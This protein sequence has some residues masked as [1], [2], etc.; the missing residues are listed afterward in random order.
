MKLNRRD[1]VKSSAFA[2]LFAAGGCATDGGI[3]N[4]V[5]V[6]VGT[7]P[8]SGRLNLAIVGCGAMGVS[9]LRQLWKDPRVRFVAAC[10]P[11][12]ES[13]FH[14][15]DA[16]TL[17]GRDPVKRLIDAKYQTSATKSVADWREVI[18]DPDVDAVLVSTG[19]Y[20]HALISAE[21]MKAGKHVYCQKPLTLGVN[22][23]KVLRTIAAKTGRIFQVGSQQRSDGRFRLAAELVRNHALGD[24]KSCTIGLCY[25]HN[26]SLKNG[27]T[28]DCTPQGIP[29]WL[30]DKAM[31]DLYLG[32]VRHWENDAY[33]PAIHAPVCWRWNSRTGNGS[34]ADWGAHHIDIL[35]WA[36]GLDATGG[37][38]AIE[39]VKTDLR[40]PVRCNRYLDQE[41]HYSFEC[42]R[43]VSGHMSATSRRSDETGFAFMAQRE[44]SLSRA[45]NLKCQTRSR[46]SRRTICEDATS[47]CTA[48]RRRMARTSSTSSTRSS[49]AVR[50]RA[51]SKSAIAARPSAIWRTLRRTQAVR[52]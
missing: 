21:A 39:N 50:A 45:A 43:T 42:M 30:G 28:R 36:L 14:G 5:E 1:F 7:P 48:T 38:I 22:E 8:P 25:A 33:I 24:C 2:T 49:R 40:D 11:I 27:Y 4:I 34:L 26:D 3:P 23:G 32:P 15:Y 9:N 20:W 44:T 52:Q 41:V 46:T 29:P 37:P 47:G 17:L 31:W 13:R 35:Q 12:K 18:A 19:D 6:P 51:R 10:D 16:K